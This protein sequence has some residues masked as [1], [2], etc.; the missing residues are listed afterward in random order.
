M[1]REE[2]KVK[3]FNVL[4][5]VADNA[6]LST[7]EAIEKAYNMGVSER[8]IVLDKIIFEIRDEQN[9]DYKCHRKTYDNCLRI[10][11]KYKAESEK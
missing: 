9:M 7:F 4:H 11:S 8:E 1:I 6:G 10:I 5:F 3:T 2:A